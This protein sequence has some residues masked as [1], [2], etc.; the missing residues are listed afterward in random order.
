[1]DETDVLIVGAGLA[2]LACAQALKSSGLNVKVLDRSHAVGGRC[3]VKTAGEGLV[4]D[5]GPVFVHGDD[6]DFL[7]WIETF[8]ADLIPGWPQVVEGSGAPCQPAAFEPGQRRF[9][10]RSGLR[11]LAQDLSRGLEVVLETEVASFLWQDSGFTVTAADRTFRAR[12]L[13]LALA[14]EQTRSLL[15]DHLAI[16][17][18]LGAFTS[19][20]C[21]TLVA[22]YGPSTPAPS[23][24]IAYPETS[25]VV[26]VASQEGLKR[27]LDPTEG[28]LFT[29]QGRPGWSAARLGAERAH[30]SGE[31]LAEA[32]RLW[33]DWALTPTS[34][35]A[36]RWKYARLDPSSHLVRPPLFDRPGSSGRLGLAGDLFHPDGGLQGAW[37]SGRALAARLMV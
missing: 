28:R 35:I 4:A 9:A 19:L 23:W 25:R 27:G 15:A 7:A 36:H 8:G 30:W 12:N 17:A 26:L 5:L 10:L 20:P 16:D 14:L 3:A 31:L 29:F 2:G 18:L 37:K 6:P 33:G 13:V 34:W 1:M 24:D 21:L 32:A 22:S 11:T